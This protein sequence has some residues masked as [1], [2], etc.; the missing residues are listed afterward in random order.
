MVRKTPGEFCEPETII[1]KLMDNH[2]NLQTYLKIDEFPKQL[3]GP[4]EKN[5][6]KKEWPYMFANGREPKCDSFRTKRSVLAVAKVN[7]RDEVEQMKYLNLGCGYEYLCYNCG[8]AKSIA[9]A[10]STISMVNELYNFNPELSTIRIVFTL[11]RYH[12]WHREESQLNYNKFYRAVCKTIKEY[13]GDDIAAILTLHNWSSKDPR[14]KHI[15][16]HAYII[17]MDTSGRLLP[18]WVRIDELKRIYKSN[19]NIDPKNPIVIHSEYYPKAK[20]RALYGRFLYDFRSPI[21]DYVEAY[22][23][24]PLEKNYLDRVGKLYRMHHI[25]YFG[26]L[27]GR[28][29]KA[30]LA[31]FGITEKSIAE[32][33]RYVAIGIFQIVK[34]FK[35]NG[36]VYYRLSNKDVIPASELI[37]QDLIY[38]TRKYRTV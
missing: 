33:M 32:V 20:L 26:W 7:E 17:P 8:N 36:V 28:K 4:L 23:G 10:R 29:K 30:Q 14:K 21:N 5:L 12:K 15:H 37:P 38:R 6:K 35:K 9:R 3:W 1:L 31:K 27:S 19:L 11:P 18:G 22:P 16:I 34:K 25:R 13:F 24:E 2:S